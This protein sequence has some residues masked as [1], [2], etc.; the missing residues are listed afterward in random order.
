MG[1]PIRSLNAIFRPRVVLGTW[2]R[3]VLRTVLRRRRRLISV[4]LGLVLIY[5]RR[6]RLLLIIGPCSPGPGAHSMYRAHNMVHLA[7][8]KLVCD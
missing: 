7:A 4:V 2:L 8:V 5:W 6:R 3:A 1:P